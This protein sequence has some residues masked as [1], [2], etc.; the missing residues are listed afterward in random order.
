VGFEGKIPLAEQQLVPPSALN[1]FV[2]LEKARAV[3]KPGAVNLSLVQLPV[4]CQSQRRRL[5]QV[6]ACPALEA[7]LFPL[8]PL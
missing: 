6:K 8:G 5:V 3:S 7:L 2:D 1:Q 4:K